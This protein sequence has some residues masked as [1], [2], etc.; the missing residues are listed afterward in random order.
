MNYPELP[1]KYA[2]DV[3]NNMEVRLL[4][5]MLEGRGKPIDMYRHAKGMLRAGYK[6]DLNNKV[7]DVFFAH[8]CYK[9]AYCKR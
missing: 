8:Y 7:E 9:R 3:E 5:V 1:R 2:E 6:V 4:Y